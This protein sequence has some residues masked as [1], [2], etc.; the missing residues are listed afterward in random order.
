[1]QVLPGVHRVPGVWWSRV[2][3]IDDVRLTLVDSGPPWVGGKVFRYIRSIG[4]DPRDLDLIL[5]THSHPDHVSSAPKITSATGAE[6]Y[7]HAR[8]TKLHAG[9]GVSLHY[10]G[11]F[12]SIDAPVPFLQRTPVSK[13]VDDGMALPILGGVTVIHTPG[14]TPGSVCYL[15]E[16]RGLLFSGDSLFSDGSRLS[17]SVPFPGS[18]VEDYRRSLDKLA[19]IQF[20]SLCGGHGEPLVGNASDK[21]RDLIATRP[22]PPTWGKYL[23]GIPRRL[24]R[25]RTLHGEDFPEQQSS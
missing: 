25:A 16:E 24:Y 23:R 21:L 8:D 20:D 4:R 17:R 11:L 12:G 2:Y 9:N 7:A 14:H 22:E 19:G 15:L 3:L 6:V 1:M 18:D 13:T 10:M 5:V